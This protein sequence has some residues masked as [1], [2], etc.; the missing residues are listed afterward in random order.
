MD[1]VG[2]QYFLLS[3]YCLCIILYIMFLMDS[4]SRSIVYPAS[5]L[6]LCQQKQ[7][8]MYLWGRTS[9]KAGFP[10]AF[11]ILQSTA[12]RST[13]CNT[14]NSLSDWTL[15][16]T[17]TLR[18]LLT[19]PCCIP[20]VQGTNQTSPLR[21][22]ARSRRSLTELPTVPA[23]ACI[24]VPPWAVAIATCPT[25]LSHVHEPDSARSPVGDEL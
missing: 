3:S 19:L 24:C 23:S 25:G 4:T 10:L 18:F 1:P 20:H 15:H 6:C 2:S 13:L 12:D 5:W 14:L 17:A 16:T 8:H 21:A 11:T 22:M 9:E 7:K